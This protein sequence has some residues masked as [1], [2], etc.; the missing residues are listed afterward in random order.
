[1]Q[2]KTIPN[3]ATHGNTYHSS[4]LNPTGAS[5]SHLHKPKKKNKRK[6]VATSLCASSLGVTAP[7]LVPRA[8]T[9]RRPARSDGVVEKG[10]APSRP[11]S[12]GTA[13]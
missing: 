11:R 12:I 5:H 2:Q 10:R 8:C 9:C 1:M 4:I 6:G 3:Y 13:G 7:E